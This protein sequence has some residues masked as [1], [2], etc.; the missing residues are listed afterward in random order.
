VR[1]RKLVV[2]GATIVILG[3]TAGV[4]SATTS[5]TA[6]H[7]NA[8]GPSVYSTQVVGP[9]LPLNSG[10]TVVLTSPDLPIGNFL[11]TFDVTL[12]LRPE[13]NVACFLEVNGSRIDQMSG[14]AGVGASKFS[15]VY[16]N[17]TESYVIHISQQASD[18]EVVCI[19]SASPGTG[20]TTGTVRMLTAVKVGQWTLRSH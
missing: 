2:L 6:W 12:L 13:T 16:A 9:N 8:T 17:S 11:V 10:N 7:G 20:S 3:T 15:P 5:S 1:V 4:A 14:A 18:V 19:Q